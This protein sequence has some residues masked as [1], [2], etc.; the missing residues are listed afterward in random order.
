MARPGRRLVMWFGGNA[1]LPDSWTV[2]D[3][4]Q[5]NMF[6]VFMIAPVIQI[7]NIGTQ[8]T[9]AFAGLDRTN[10]LMRRTGRKSDPR[11]QPRI[12]AHPAATSSLKTSSSPTSRKSPSSTASA[13]SPSPEPSPR[14]SAPPAP[15][16]PPSSRSICA[17]HTPDHRPHPGRRRRPRPR[18]T[19]TPTAPS[20]A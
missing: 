20:S 4:F 9:E 11:P 5:Y 12:A 13:S 18:S 17:F 7:V 2:G 6:L 14:S 10:E 3:Y 1:V 15:A 19:S 16:N 8:L